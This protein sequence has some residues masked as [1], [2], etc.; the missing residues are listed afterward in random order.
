[1]VSRISQHNVISHTP[2]YAIALRGQS[3][4]RTG[5]LETTHVGRTKQSEIGGV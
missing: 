2:M 3:K 4:N 1:M 5:Y